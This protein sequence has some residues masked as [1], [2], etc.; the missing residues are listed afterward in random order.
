MIVIYQGET[1]D[2]LIST[3]PDNG[4]S[5]RKAEVSV[6]FFSRDKEVGVFASTSS[7]RGRAVP[8]KRLDDDV[9]FLRLPGRCSARMSGCYDIEVMVRYSDGTF[10]A[11][12]GA[13]VVKEAAIGRIC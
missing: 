4:G 5:L 10:V 11:R 13:I 2:M 1:V 8:I 12:K 9:L 3:P 6:T 7:C